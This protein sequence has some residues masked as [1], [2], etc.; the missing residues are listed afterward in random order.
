MPFP[1]AFS[2]EKADIDAIFECIE[3]TE[4]INVGPIGVADDG[5]R[6]FFNLAHPP[7]KFKETRTE[8]KLKDIKTMIVGWISASD[9]THTLSDMTVI[10][11]LPNGTVQQFHTDFDTTTAAREYQEVPYL[12]IIPIQKGNFFSLL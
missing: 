10:V 12:A 3:A 6:R 4:S 5:R 1:A 2:F 8:R 11:S 7:D 9:R